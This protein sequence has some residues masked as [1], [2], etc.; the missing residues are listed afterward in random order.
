[1]HLTRSEDDL[2]SILAGGTIEA[3]APYGAGRYYPEVQHLHRSVCLTEI[4]LHEL[5]RMTQHRPWGIVFDKEKLRGKFNAQPVWYVSDPSPQWQALHAAMDGAARKSDAPLWRLTPF[6]ESVR[7]LQSGNPNDWRWEREW[8][9]CGDLEFEL[10]DIAMIISSEAGATAIVDEVSVG[11][12]W[13]SPDGGRAQWADGFTDGWDAAID[14]M[15]DRFFETFTSLD[16]SGMPW[17]S[18][19]KAYVQLVEFYETADAMDEVFGYLLPDLH[20][21]IESALNDESYQWCLTFDLEHWG[22]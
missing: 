16:N 12:P 2:I 20:E 3:R 22:D 19:D 21:A 5:G 7:S 10:S 8:R 15:L 17:D 1:M 13:V 9:V 4:P 6:I 11:L 14:K 18:E